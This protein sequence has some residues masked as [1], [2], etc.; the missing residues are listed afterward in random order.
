MATTAP[1]LPTLIA[2]PEAPHH[3]EITISSTGDKD[4]IG[5]D[6]RDETDDGII[7]CDT[8]AITALPILGRGQGGGGVVEAEASDIIVPPPCPTM[9]TTQSTLG[10]ASAPVHMCPP[11]TPPLPNL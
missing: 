7:P 3:Q 6:V 9:C 11:P 8:A 2:L 4:F 1:L 10:G 5:I